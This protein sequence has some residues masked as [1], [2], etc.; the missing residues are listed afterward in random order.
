MRRA[1]RT[2]STHATIRDRLRQ[3]GF[4]V[5]DTSQLGRYF[6]DLVAGKHGITVLI[7][8]KSPKKV[9]KTKGDG[10]SAG[11][12]NFKEQWRGSAVIVSETTQGVL[13][14]FRLIVKRVGWSI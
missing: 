6:P 11:Q 2:D 12:T 7:E 10:L 3:A 1:A 8:A 4:S 13:D 14:A 9:R 5:M